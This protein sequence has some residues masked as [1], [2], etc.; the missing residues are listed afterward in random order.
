MLKRIL[1]YFFVAIAICYS[2][3]SLFVIPQFKEN[4]TCSGIIVNISD[5]DIKTITDEEVMDIL[6]EANLTPELK[7]MNEI[8][9]G[10]IE[11]HFNN[12][13]LIKE[14]QVYKGNKDFVN[15][16]I[17]CREPIIRIHD[18]ENKTYCVDSDGNIIRGINRALHLP[19]A[20]G[21]IVDSMATK[22]IK[23]IASAIKESKFWTAQIEQIYFNDKKEVILIPR[24]GDHIIELGTTENI[25]NK[26]E[27][28]YTFYHE[29]MNKI[30]WNKYSKLNIE[31]GD[32]VICTKRD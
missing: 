12:I 19:I 11:Q 28:L 8:D 15:I 5:S 3:F 20:T 17:D 26:L 18:K 7:K 31:F 13:S 10:E 14:C 16:N 25:N 24:V 27:K 29:G 30:G 22:E 1:K 4:G 6:N 32:K 21:N 23:D 2:L 9:C